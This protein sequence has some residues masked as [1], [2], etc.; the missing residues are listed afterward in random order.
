MHSK[1]PVVRA[2]LNHSANAL[3]VQ[4]AMER[5]VE[6]EDEVGGGGWLGSGE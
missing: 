6:C 4:E 3:L 2:F 1:N 5:F